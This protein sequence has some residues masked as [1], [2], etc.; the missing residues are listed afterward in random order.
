MWKLIVAMTVAVGTL[1]T[2]LPKAIADDLP[3]QLN[4]GEH[5]LSL[6][7]SGVRTKALLPLYTAGLYLTRPSNAAAQ[8]IAADEPMAL[9][10]KITSAF[11]SQAS[12]ISSLEDGFEN[13]TGGKTQPL[14]EQIEQFRKCFNDDI[15][16]GDVFDLVY[17]PEHGVIIN[18]NG[19]LKG[20]VK[21]IEFK[22]ALYGIW[23]CDKPADT[24]LKQAL[25]TSGKVR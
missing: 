15:K 1:N 12:L 20:V 6:N 7:G 2:A 21:S 11:V 18:K 17:L 14:R 4:A 25:L 22:R 10:I 24:A 16:K 9:R 3:Q 13:A 23:L 19:K 5:R 8:V